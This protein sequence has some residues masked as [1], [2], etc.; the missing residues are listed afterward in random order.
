MS[1]TVK[2]KFKNYLKGEKKLQYAILPFDDDDAAI[3]DSIKKNKP[4]ITKNTSK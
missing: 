1:D 4:R 3:L 2:R